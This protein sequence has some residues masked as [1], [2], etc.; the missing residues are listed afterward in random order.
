MV[1]ANVGQGRVFVFGNDLLFRTQP[2]GNY[3]FFFNAMYL[4]VA[5]DMK[6]GR[7]NDT[8]TNVATD[9]LRCDAAI[10]SILARML[11]ALSI[12]GLSGSRA[13]GGSCMKRLRLNDR[14]RRVCW[15]SSLEW[16]PWRSRQRQR[17]RA[18]GRQAPKADRRPMAEWGHNIGDDYFLVN[19]QQLMAYWQ[20]L[21]KRV[22]AHPRRGDRQDVRGPAD[23]DGDHHV[24][25]QL[26]EARALQ[27]D[28]EPARQRRGADRR[29]RRSALAKEGK[30]VVWIDGGLHATETLGAQQL[31]EHVWQM[32]EPHR[33]GDAALPGRRD[34]ARACW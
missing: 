29:R 3:K 34:S 13:R 4:S 24:A 31:L 25:G 23:A 16:L 27:G 5:P 26:R 32:V 12:L 2:H 20:K 11:Q 14:V 19:Y 9:N 22:A 6:A 8:V 1:E 33:R 21:A 17:R 30:A 7:A 15:P 18:S 10:E 28:L